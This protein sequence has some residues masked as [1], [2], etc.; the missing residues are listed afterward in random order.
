MGS[1]QAEAA[2][3]EIDDRAHVSA[4]R[5]EGSEILRAVIALES[6]GAEAR[7]RFID[8]RADSKV[9]LVVLEEDVVSRLVALD[10]FVFGEKGLVL[11]A[12]DDPFQVLGAVHEAAYLRV[13]TPHRVGAEVA[14]DTPFEVDR[15]AD[16]YDPPAP[17]AHD[18][19]A[20]FFR[21]VLEFLS[22]CVVH[23]RGEAIT[24][25]RWP[26]VRGRGRFARRSARRPCCGA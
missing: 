4:A 1:A 5:G 2:F 20:G 17:V 10:E 16:V 11:A 8:S 14:A 24:C 3:E 23:C 13:A 9:A 22:D 19:T 7:Q 12:T 15:L 6:A 25:D 26:R 18:V 21:K